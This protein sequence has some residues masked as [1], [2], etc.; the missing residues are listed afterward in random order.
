MTT[1]IA[2]PF[3]NFL[4]N[5]K[6]RSAEVDANNAEIQTK[7]NA[8]TAI[9]REYPTLAAEIGLVVDGTYQYGHVRR[10]GAIPGGAAATNRQAIQNALTANTGMVEFEDGNYNIDDELFPVSNQRIWLSPGTTIKQL[11]ANKNIFKAILKD[12]LWIHCN[13]GELY[14]EG[15]WSAAW[16]GAGGH[17]DRAIQLLGCTNTGVTYPRVRN[18][19]YSGIVVFGGTHITIHHPTVEGTHALSTVLHQGD[20]YQLGIWVACDATYGAYED[21]KINMPTIYNVN[22][23]ILASSVVGNPEGSLVISMPH[24]YSIIGQHGMYLSCSKITV[25]SPHIHDCGL[26]GFKFY[27][28]VINEV[29]TDMVCTDVNIYNCPNGQAV[30]VGNSTAGS[31]SGWMVTGKARSCA[32]AISISGDCRYGTVKMQSDAMSQ[33][34]LY[35]TD[36]G[37]PLKGI[38]NCEIEMNSSNTQQYG[39]VIDATL[40]TNNRVRF[41]NFRSGLNGTLATSPGILV[42]ACTSLTLESPE[43]LDDAGTM[44]YGIFGQAGANFRITGTPVIKGYLTQAIRIIGGAQCEWHCSGQ[45]FTTFATGFAASGDFVIP[46]TPLKIGV[47]TTSAANLALWALTMADESA[48]QV[49]VILTGKKVGSAERGAFRTSILCYRDAAG[50]ATLEGAEFGNAGRNSA[51]FPAA[52]YTW[53]VNANQIR[54]LVNSGSAISIDWVATITVSRL[55]N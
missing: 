2:L 43:L 25:S 31:I 38:S 42:F 47:Q 35:M 10:Y 7:F 18:C 22:Q 28:G 39:A 44:Q 45:D 11:T 29:L 12:R 24:C 1:T 8:H 17:E 54:L 50:V 46:L 52:P 16:S 23:G 14:G 36:G 40:S 49:T 20:N 5:T 34:G 3:P 4:P 13:M 9:S 26:D 51:G 19:G 6:A 27:T 15:T 41:K 48:Y 30:T 37:S 33:Y 53:N 55:V 32:R 21:V